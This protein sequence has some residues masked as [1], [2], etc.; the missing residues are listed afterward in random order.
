MIGWWIAAGVAVVAC[1]NMLYANPTHKLKVWLQLVVYYAK[2]WVLW[3]WCWALWHLWVEP[4][5]F[6]AMAAA[7]AL[8]YLYMSWIEPNRLQIR[9]QT[10]NLSQTT[11]N[12]QIVTPEPRPLKLAVIGD[13]HIG[14]FSPSAQLQHVVNCV[15][16]LDVDTVLVTGDWLY[17]A[18]SDIMGK[19]SV[20]KALNKPCYSVL[21]EDDETQLQHISEK[22][23]Q[24]D[25]GNYLLINETITQVL[26]TMG[27]T[28]LGQTKTPYQ[29]GIHLNDFHLLGFSDGTVNTTSVTYPK[30]KL[31]QKTIILTHD[32]KQFLANSQHSQYLNEHTLIIAGQ[33]H[34]GQVNVPWLTPWLVKALTG[35]TSVN[36]LTH[37]QLQIDNPSINFVTNAKLKKRKQISFYSWTN[38]GIG[39]TG[40]PFRFRCPPRVDVLTII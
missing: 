11:Q 8:L 23:Q 40:L 20:L 31:K 14:I 30:P 16:R 7:L 19:L 4:Q 13:I 26:Q 15:N 32:I 6:Y 27:I 28:V 35:N 22:Y 36:G 34:G 12:S 33:T 17:H 29:T 2:Y 38:T 3:L 21:S 24:S 25:G 10:I 9:Y 5:G 1:L 39:L 18:G 37:H